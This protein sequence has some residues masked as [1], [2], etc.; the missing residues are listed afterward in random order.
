MVITAAIVDDTV[1]AGAF[2]AIMEGT[3][4]VPP[5]QIENRYLSAD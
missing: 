3:S 5:I 2:C 4:T 1:D